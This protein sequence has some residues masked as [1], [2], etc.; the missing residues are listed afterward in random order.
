MNCAEVNTK[1]SEY[2][3][4][5]LDSSQRSQFEEHLK[6]C[7]IC[8]N[9]LHE[10]QL[11]VKLCQDIGDE[12]IPERFKE[13][14]N[15]R[16]VNEREIAKN[17]GNIHSTRN[18]YI[19]ILST[20]AA[21]FVLIFLLK[22]FYQN[23]Y[24]MSAKHVKEDNGISNAIL[25]AESASSDSSDYSNSKDEPHIF[26]GSVENKK[27]NGD[28]TVEIEPSRSTVFRVN[29]DDI[30]LTSEN[31][32]NN[33]IKTIDITLKIKNKD[34]EK[35][36]IK[37]FL[38]SNGAELTEKDTIIN[39]KVPNQTYENFIEELKKRFGF[40]NII[41]GN[42]VCEDITQKKEKLSNDANDADELEKLIFDTDY[43]FINLTITEKNR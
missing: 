5:Q 14:L 7:S 32:E 43:T 28:T 36:S 35:D 26:A 27:E 22:S 9:E 41:I 3:D 8:R 20:M 31:I 38:T 33:S 37:L 18:R 25:S 13:K 30:S 29:S 40:E 10:I 21:S 42:I 23:G 19:K 39:L 1:I 4:D 24:F 16:L 2:I 15:Q 11:V 17:K 12:E 6:Q 34:L